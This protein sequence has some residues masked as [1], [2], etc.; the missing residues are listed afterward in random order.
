[1]Y[2]KHLFSQLSSS[3]SYLL[4]QY[5]VAQLYSVAE[6]SKENTGGGEGIEVISNEPFDLDD[7]SIDKQKVPDEPLYANGQYFTKGQYTHKIYHVA[8]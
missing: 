5:Q 1:M 3:V 4:F 6:A 2:K 8:R 7:R